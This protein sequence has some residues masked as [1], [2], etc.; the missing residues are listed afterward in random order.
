M[1]QK[2]AW[3]MNFGTP[4]YLYAL[5]A[6][7]IPIV[8]HLWS[9]NT[10]TRV[11]FGSLRFLKETETKTTKHLFPS[12]LLLLLIRIV[13]FSCL[14][15]LFAAPFIQ[16]P[17][18]N[19]TVYL[20]D[21]NLE[22]EAFSKIKDQLNA[23]ETY[24]LSPMK[25][26]ITDPIHVGNVDSWSSLKSFED[27]DSLVVYSTQLLKQFQGNI[28]PLAS[29]V[30]WIQIPIQDKNETLFELSKK[31]QNTQI[32]VL[33]NSKSLLYEHKNVASGTNKLIKIH[34]KANQPYEELATLVEKAIAAI[35]Q[36]NPITFELVNVKESTQFSPDDWLIWLSS[37]Q[38]P[39]RQKLIFLDAHSNLLEKKTENI[40]GLNPEISVDKMLQTNFPLQLETALTAPLNSELNEY[41]LR[42]IP[43]AYL[44]EGSGLQKSALADQPITEWALIAFLIL[45]LVERL[46]SQIIIK[47]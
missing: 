8:I 6:I 29:K 17:A 27:Y 30:N 45:L 46:V 3:L 24:W 26:A 2:E 21:P 44:G 22:K 11:P 28:T 13:L 37:E 47:K 23:E 39:M 34:L 31:N 42:T 5:A 20:V 10:K 7:S 35:N 16:K 15:L 25:V 36:S 38:A 43:K 9:K 1:A 18:S 41:D 33:A 14:A 40:Y 32:N 19:K 4:T 12:E